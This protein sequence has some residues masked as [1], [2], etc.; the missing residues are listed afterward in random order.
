MF[1]S[2]QHCFSISSTSSYLGI[3]L[4]SAIAV[5]NIF[6]VHLTKHSDLFHDGILY[7]LLIWDYYFLYSSFK[8]LHISSFYLCFPIDLCLLCFFL[9]LSLHKKFPLIAAIFINK[10]LHCIFRCISFFSYS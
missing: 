2:H 9:C 3:S 7:V 5:S 10:Y 6:R 4:T 1:S 8:Y